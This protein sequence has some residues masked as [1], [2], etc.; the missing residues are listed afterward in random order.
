L[1]LSQ[2]CDAIEKSELAPHAKPVLQRECVAG[3]VLD[4]QRGFGQ[5]AANEAMKLAIERA[6]LTGVAA[7]TLHNCYHSGRLAVYSLM[8]AK[9]GMIGIVMVNAGGG[10]QSV[11]PFGGIE[12]RLATNPFAIAVPSGGDYDPVLDVATSMVPEGKVRNYYR[13]GESLPGDWIIDA[14]GRPATDAQHFYGP[15]AGAILPWGG[16]VGYKGF[17]LAFLIDVIAGALSGAGCCGPDVVPARD[18]VLLL[19]LDIEQFVSGQTFRR[20]VMTLI[21]HVK[22]CPPAPGYE[23]VFVPGELEHREAQKRRR[24]GI[25]VDDTTWQEIQSLARRYSIG[26]DLNGDF[27]LSYGPRPAHL[28]SDAAAS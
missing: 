11:A 4:G 3:A 5:V 12:R 16:S 23:E 26:S 21:H 13:R 17:G 15:P 22:S 6:R 9:A 7:V 25:L 14:E 2:Y 18:G 24:V 10:G 28:P 27:D 1:R 20:Q 19:A 8:A